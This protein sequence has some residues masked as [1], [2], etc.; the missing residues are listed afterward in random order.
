MEAVILACE[1]LFLHGGGELCILILSM[2][3]KVIFAYSEKSEIMRQCVSW[4]L[5]WFVAFVSDV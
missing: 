3:G 4:G 5:Y 1:L 2:Y